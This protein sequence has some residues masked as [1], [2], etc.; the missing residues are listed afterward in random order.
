MTVGELIKALEK[1]PNKD[2]PVRIY[3]TSNYDMKVDDVLSISDVDYSIS[4]RLDINAV[5]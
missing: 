4:D 1:E 2:K 3:V 5:R